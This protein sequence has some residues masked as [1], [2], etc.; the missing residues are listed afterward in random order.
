[1]GRVD[2]LDRKQRGVGGCRT[3]TPTNIDF[4]S[5]SGSF[6]D[7]PS[8]THTIAPPT[9]HASPNATDTKI[10]RKPRANLSLLALLGLVVVRAR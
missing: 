7:I 6:N 2:C 8:P 4:A 9:T 5:N 10:I 1:M 3:S